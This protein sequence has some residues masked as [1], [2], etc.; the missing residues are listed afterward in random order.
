MTGKTVYCWLIVMT[1]MCLAVGGCNDSD[2]PDASPPEEF[3]QA[4]VDGDANAVKGFLGQG[5]DVNVQDIG[6]EITPLHVAAARGRLEVAELL[7]AR[8]AKINLTNYWNQTPLHAGVHCGNPITWDP[9]VTRGRYEIAKLLISKG[10]HLEDKDDFGQT[11]LHVAAAG[12]N[13]DIV[14]V[15]LDNG[16]SVN[17]IDANCRTPLDWVDDE[18]KKDIVAL[19]LKHSGKKWEDLPPDTINKASVRGDKAQVEKFLNSGVDVD[20]KVGWGRTPLWQACDKG[21]HDIAELLIQ[22]GA[23]IGAKNTDGET[24]LHQAV[25][26]GRIGIVRLLITRGANIN[27]RDDFTYIPLHEAASIGDNSIVKLLIDNGADVNAISETDLTPLDCVDDEYQATAA[28]LRK[29]GGKTSK[30]LE[31]KKK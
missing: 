29:H 2:T 27:A 15:L 25:S 24:P 1:P 9:E 16:A 8:G 12:G 3:W 18:H 7:I 17:T 20:T 23:D 5:V 10:A 22:K 19:L 11:P 30:E 4:I 26:R 13:A 6:S 28:L 21:H 14:K 31:A